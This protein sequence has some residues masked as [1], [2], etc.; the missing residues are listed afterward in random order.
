[1]KVQTIVSGQ[2]DVNTYVAY[3]E[4]SRE[5]F[6]IDV[7]CASTVLRFLNEEQLNCTHILITHGHF[8]HIAGVK[9]LKEN[10]GAKV[11]IHE[12]D[13]AGLYDER[14]NLSG[15]IG[16]FLP[17]TKADIILHDGDILNIIGKEIKVIHTPGHSRGG[18]CFVIDGKNQD[19]KIIFSGDT[20]FRLSVGRTDFD[21]CD[22]KALFD[23]IEQKLF[24]LEG[25]YK[26]YPGHMRATTLDDEKLKN[27][28]VKR[29][30]TS[31][32]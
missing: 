32:W 22:A 7:G 1:M 26:V 10:T 28:F 6:V 31:L 14:I 27:P 5:C 25:N 9:E 19:E 3:D 30:T 11:C 20:L 16:T 18:V 23:S 12:Y 17:P 15:M 21:N 8:D 24:T 13:A 29:R 4:Q 2:L